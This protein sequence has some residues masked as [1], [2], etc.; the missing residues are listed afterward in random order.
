MN[1]QR[2]RFEIILAHFDGNQTEFGKTIG[3]SKQT[4]SGWL[5]GRFPIPEDSAIT[6]EMVHG[7]RREWILRGESPQ[8]TSRYAAREPLLSENEKTKDTILLKQ[9]ESKKGLRD[10]IEILAG[11]SKKEFEIARKLLL[12]LSEEDSKLK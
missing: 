6:I 2:K 11:L 4:I 12:G 8:R 5:S 1:E 10:L 9:I 3:K 7:Y